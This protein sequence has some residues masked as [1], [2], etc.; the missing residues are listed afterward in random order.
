MT[1]I[2]AGQYKLDNYYSIKSD[3]GEW[4]VYSNADLFDDGTFFTGDWEITFETKKQ[5]TEWIE[6]S[7]GK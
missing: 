4:L 1:K 2:A 5:C 3:S 7:R 6:W